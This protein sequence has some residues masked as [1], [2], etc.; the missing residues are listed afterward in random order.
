M[1]SW[2]DCILNRR[3]SIPP[4]PDSIPCFFEVYNLCHFF[5]ARFY[6]S[7]NDVWNLARIFWPD[8][9]SRRPDSILSWPDSIPHRT[10]S[11][12]LRIGYLPLRTDSLPIRTYCL[13][14][15]TDYLPSDRLF[16]FSARL[17]T[18][19]ARLYQPRTHQGP[20]PP[21]QVARSIGCIPRF[22]RYRI[23]PENLGQILYFVF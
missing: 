23:W 14:P 16:T 12:P 13:P 15:R 22:S 9:I 21:L 6:T 7:K 17:F 20:Y 2:P 5:L 19:W 4:G 8:S 11:I 3:D 1:I 18:S 10:D